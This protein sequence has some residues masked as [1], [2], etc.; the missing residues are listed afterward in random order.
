MKSAILILKSSLQTG[1]LWR[2]VCGLQGRECAPEG[3]ALSALKTILRIAGM[4]WNGK[5][6]FP[7]P[8][9]PSIQQRPLPFRGQCPW[10]VS[11][12]RTFPAS[13]PESTKTRCRCPAI[14]YG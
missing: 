14:A 5:P 8:F 7:V 12:A 9:H 1:R 10:K 2:P 3:R 11:P 4:K 13:L 6:S